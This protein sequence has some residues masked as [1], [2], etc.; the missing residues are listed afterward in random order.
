MTQNIAIRFGIVSEHT[1]VGNDV[2]S[3]FGCYLQH[4]V[5][6]VNVIASLDRHSHHKQD[7]V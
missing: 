1:S 2:C 3:S 7:F 6:L 5:A 4:L